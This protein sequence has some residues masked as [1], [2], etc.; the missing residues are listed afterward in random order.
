MVAGGCASSALTM[1]SKTVDASLIVDEAKYNQ[2]SKAFRTEREMKGMSRTRLV[3][4]CHRRFTTPRA[5]GF[6]RST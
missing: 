1:I 2:R 6:T 3:T 5:G 4:E